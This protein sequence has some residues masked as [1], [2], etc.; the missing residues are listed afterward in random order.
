MYEVYIGGVGLVCRTT[1]RRAAL[2]SFREQVSLSQ[3]FGTRC[4]G[5]E[6]HVFLDGDLVVVYDPELGELSEVFRAKEV[7]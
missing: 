5:K 3:S 4:A 2:A 6:V 1:S 7:V